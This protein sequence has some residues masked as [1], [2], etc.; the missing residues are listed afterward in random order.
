MSRFEENRHRAA[1]E[2]LPHRERAPQRV[3]RLVQGQ[4]LERLRELMERFV[5]ELDRTARRGDALALA[6]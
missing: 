5:V 3:A 6:P 2:R 4:S 1:S